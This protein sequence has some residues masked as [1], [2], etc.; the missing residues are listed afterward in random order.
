MFMCIIEDKDKRRFY[1]SPGTIKHIKYFHKIDNP[2]GFIRVVLKSP[3]AIIESK[4]EAKTDLYYAQRGK[5]S[6]RVVVVDTTHNR[7]KTAYMERKIK[8][9]KIK[10]ISPKLIN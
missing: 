5:G 10:W 4:W 9:G 2:E 8:E 6:Y 1:L 7:I 3:L